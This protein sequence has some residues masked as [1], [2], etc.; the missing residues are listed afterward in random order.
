M[1]RSEASRGGSQQAENS[2]TEAVIFFVR[3]NLKPN[4]QVASRN[5]ARD[6]YCR[7]AQH[8]FRFIVRGDGS[9][10]LEAG[11]M[12]RKQLTMRVELNCLNEVI[13]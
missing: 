11:S 6:N 10:E 12:H 7:S 9:T 8:K 4:N 2:K 5:Q 1:K 3:S 13:V